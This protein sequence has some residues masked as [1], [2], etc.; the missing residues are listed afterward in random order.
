MNRLALLALLAGAAV[1][2]YGITSGGVVRSAGQ[3]IPGATVTASRDGQK[4][5][6][7]T[8]ERGQYTLDL[9]LGAW[10]VDVEMFGFVVGHRDIKVEEAQ[11]PPAVEWTLELRPRPPAA[12][13]RR[14]GPQAAANGFQNIELIQREESQALARMNEAPAAAEN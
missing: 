3:P 6:T 1:P 8:D 5:V 2:V 4:L 12:G 14:A 11:A 7:S 13:P 10:T 9:A